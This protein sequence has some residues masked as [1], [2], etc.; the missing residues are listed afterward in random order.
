MV[1][2]FQFPYKAAMTKNPNVFILIA[3]LPKS[4]VPCY[5]FIAPTYVGRQTKDG[6]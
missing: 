4:W 2:D 5:S 1:T 6:P 3:A